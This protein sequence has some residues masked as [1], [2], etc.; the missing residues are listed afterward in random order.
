[1]M[2]Q[3]LNIIAAGAAKLPETIDDWSKWIIEP[4]CCVVNLLN[5]TQIYGAFDLNGIIEGLPGR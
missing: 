2:S 1:M 4:T 3:Y 5:K